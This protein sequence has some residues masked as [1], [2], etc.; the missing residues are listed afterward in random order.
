MKRE[1]QKD[2][3]IAHLNQGLPITPIE[4]LE[5]FGCFRLAAIIHTLKHIEGMN[6][7]KELIKNKYGTKYA[8]YKIIKKSINQ[9][10]LDE[11]NPTGEW[12]Q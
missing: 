3:I 10:I 11:L 6:I 9:S 4:A 5:R 7:G 8:K 2:K 1:T 12:K